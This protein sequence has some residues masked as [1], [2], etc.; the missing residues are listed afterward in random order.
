MA[1][2]QID[3]KATNKGL[4]NTLNESESLVKQFATGVKIALATAAAAFVIDKIKDN[5]SSWISEAS[6][7]ADATNKLAAQVERTGGVAGYSAAQLKQMADEMEGLTGV[8]SEAIQK[9]QSLLIVFDNIRGDEFRRATT[10]ANDLAKV[11]EVDVASAARVVGKALDDP[12]DAINALARSGIDFSEAQKDMIK[13]M[14]ESGDVVG[15]QQVILDALEAKVGGVAEAMGGTFSGRLA[16]FEAKLGDVGEAIGTA[17]IPWLE[18]LLPAGDLVVDGMNAIV[19][20]L[21][22]MVGSADNFQ[23]SFSEV[24]VS[25]LEYVT[26]I[27]VSSF[28]Y[29]LAF[30]ETWYSQVER[31]SFQTILAFVTSFEEL[32]YWLTEAVP[33][34]LTWFSENWSNI[35]NDIFVYT[36]NVINNMADN[37][38]MF[39]ANIG[40]WL[41]GENVDWKWKGLSDG[42]TATI[43]ELPEIAS[44]ELSQTEKYLQGSIKQL[45]KSISETFD[46]RNQQGQE[47]VDKIFRPKPKEEKPIVPTESGAPRRVVGKQDE[48]KDKAAKDAKDAASK[49]PGSG[50]QAQKQE[51]TAGQV[52]G[53]EELSKKIEAAK[54]QV[55][56]LAMAREAALQVPQP[57]AA[58]VKGEPDIKGESKVDFKALAEAIINLLDLSLTEA[59]VTNDQLAKLNVG[60]A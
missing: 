58:K 32:K 1:T 57:I 24:I 48:D 54:P 15:A 34:Y 20:I 26:S 52:V 36:G 7:A 44:R 18:A 33:A 37:L 45:D 38:E 22:E 10:A 31:F 27:F 56:Q 46:K 40:K 43:K 16:I 28:T 8:E 4:S 35:F 25:G 6:K 23:A 50:T 55:E 19:E 13:S 17:L 39:F 14:A 51:S 60:M 21:S 59:E 47:F 12:V 29:T 3:I 2:A 53:L 11:M 5:F 30:L 41:A 49:S 9:A 42:F